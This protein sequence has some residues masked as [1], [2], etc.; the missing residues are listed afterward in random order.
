[1]SKYEKIVQ[2][3]FNQ[4]FLDNQAIDAGDITGEAVQKMNKR[5]DNISKRL[6]DAENLN[7]QLKSILASSKSF[8]DTQDEMKEV[9]LNST[10]PCS[11]NFI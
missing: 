1:M 8:A 4:A 5:M 11:N 2:K 9:R 3:F 7:V 10:P 6:E